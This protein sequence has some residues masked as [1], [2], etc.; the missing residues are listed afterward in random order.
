MVSGIKP[1]L[2]Q[3]KVRSETIADYED[4][5][6]VLN[7]VEYNTYQYAK[8]L[9]QM[10]E[11]DRASSIL[12]GSNTPHLYFLRLYA[13]YMAGEK[14]R[15][16]S[17]QDGLG[18]AEDSRE[19]NTEL[20]SIE[21]EL[22]HDNANNKLDS[23]SL[24]LYG[25]I[26]RKRDSNVKA[27]IVLLDSIKKYEYNWSVWME[28][29]CIIKTQK[30]FDDIQSLLNQHM[31]S[32]I[33]KELFLAKLCIDLHQPT[34]L[35]KEIMDPLTVYFPNSPHIKSQWA[36]MFYENMGNVR[37]CVWDNTSRDFNFFF[38]TFFMVRL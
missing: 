15:E 37:E 24:Y 30:Q 27:A 2:S 9:F 21:R 32:S 35:F 36:T 6:F 29:A 12:C 28:L 18:T 14:R 22:E 25:I 4:V 7:E 10:R 3:N 23:F 38:N 5:S 1:G 33:M 16:E 19:P 13:Q 26:L 34:S 11:F 17:I 8:T 31:G 20:D